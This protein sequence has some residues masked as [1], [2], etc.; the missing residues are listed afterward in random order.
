MFL[1]LIK[2]PMQ[3]GL[4]F[5][6]LMAKNKNIIKEIGYKIIQL[7]MK[8]MV[9]GPPK[10]RRGILEVKREKYV[11]VELLMTLKSSS[12]GVYCFYRKL[13]VTNCQI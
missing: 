11:L 7:V 6:N 13:V 1:Q 4:V 5:F 10:C 8:H 12:I 2:D 3:M 9:H